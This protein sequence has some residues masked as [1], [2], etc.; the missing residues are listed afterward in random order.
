MLLLKSKNMSTNLI[1]KF[2]NST[3]GKTILAVLSNIFNW[4]HQESFFGVFKRI[5]RKFMK[6]LFVGALNTAF[7]YFVYSV[8]VALNFSHN[9][10][11]TVQYI[12]GVF[13][14]FKTTGTIVFKNNDN[15]RIMRFFLSYVF[16][17]SIN[18]VCLNLLVGS[19]VGKYA[20]QAIMVLPM[21]VLSFLIFKTFVF[22]TK[23][24]GN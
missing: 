15:S 6:F 3:A 24:Q 22:K 21:A 14:N 8:F 17:Y 13:W 11:L 9:I 12:L 5:D 7:G 16:T 23:S 18:L 19:G 10:A 1:T 4:I 20:A 2:K